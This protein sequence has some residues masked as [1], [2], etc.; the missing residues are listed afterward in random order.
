MIKQIA[1]AALSVTALSVAVPAQH[2]EFTAP[3]SPL[4][5][6][7]CYIDTRSPY[8]RSFFRNAIAVTTYDVWEQRDFWAMQSFRALQ[9]STTRLARAASSPSPD[10][11]QVRKHA[12]SVSKKSHAARA[13]I[14]PESTDRWEQEEAAAATRTLAMTMSD[15]AAIECL[16]SDVTAQMLARRTAWPPDGNAEEALVAN[17]TRIEALARRIEVDLK[18]KRNP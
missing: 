13:W 5:P 7:V 17:L 18:Q 4:V 8:D 11:G 14:W 6:G 12:V 9:R 1:A 15:V 3:G 10:L 2:Q 16:L